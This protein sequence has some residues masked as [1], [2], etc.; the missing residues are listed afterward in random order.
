MK[1]WQR[2]TRFSPRGLVVFPLR[3]ERTKAGEQGL[4]RRRDAA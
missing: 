2:L 1:I 3:G 4:A